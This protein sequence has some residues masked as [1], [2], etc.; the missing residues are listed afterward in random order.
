[1]ISLQI[2]KG[3]MSLT[4]KLKTHAM[5]KFCKENKQISEKVESNK[6]EAHCIQKKAE[7]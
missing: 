2:Q 7:N 1:M 6:V 5:K 4:L 3:K